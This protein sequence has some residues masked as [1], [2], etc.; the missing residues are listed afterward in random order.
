MEETLVHRVMPCQQAEVAADNHRSWFGKGFHSVDRS[1]PRLLYF[2]GRYRDKGNGMAC[3]GATGSQ[4]LNLLRVA[5]G[6]ASIVHLNGARDLRRQLAEAS[7]PCGDFSREYSMSGLRHQQAG[8]ALLSLCRFHPRPGGGAHLG[9][10]F[11]LLLQPTNYHAN[12]LAVAGPVSVKLTPESLMIIQ[13]QTG[14]D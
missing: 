9:A 14:V 4:P 8:R 1:R 6:P 10:V 2:R 7:Q 11:L 5:R 12:P 13:E 3:L